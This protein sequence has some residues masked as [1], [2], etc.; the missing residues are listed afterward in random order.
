MKYLLLLISITFLF[1]CHEIGKQDTEKEERVK[2]SYYESGKVK[3]EIFYDDSLNIILANNY[4]EDGRIHSTINYKFNKRNGEAKWYYK[5]GKVYRITPYVN[6]KKHGI[7]KKYYETGEL[8]AGI[9][10]KEGMLGKDVKEYKKD[11]ELI[12]KYPQL[13][14]EKIDNLSMYNQYVIKL[15]LSNKSKNVVFYEDQLID[16]SY[17]PLKPRMIMTNNGVGEIKYH[18]PKGSVK[19][20]TVYVIAKT[21]SKHGNPILIYKEINLSIANR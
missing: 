8:K 20:E 17:L 10:Y 15:N 14:V 19:N 5:S 7:Q 13:N 18:I 12:T 9:P 2:R 6:D 4:Y 3:A 1:S 11:G 16:N 21:K